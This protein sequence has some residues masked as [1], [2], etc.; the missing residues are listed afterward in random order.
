MEQKRA[1]AMFQSS[2]VSKGTRMKQNDDDP[3]EIKLKLY[4]T[5][6]MF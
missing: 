2:Q 3:D 6:K 4:H 1:T 5:V